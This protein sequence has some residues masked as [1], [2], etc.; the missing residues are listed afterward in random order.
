MTRTPA[1]PGPWPDRRAAAVGDPAEDRHPAGDP[2]AL[3][4]D[5]GIGDVAGKAAVADRL[6]L[7]DG[8]ARGRRPA[9][10]PSSS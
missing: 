9:S 2:V 7:V 3:D 8:V 4:A 5:G 1:T 6:G 10:L